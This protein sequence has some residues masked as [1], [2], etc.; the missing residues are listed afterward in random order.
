MYRLLD[1]SGQP[2]KIADARQEKPQQ[3][4]LKRENRPGEPVT[5]VA[6]TTATQICWR[7]V[8]SAGTQT[9]LR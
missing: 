6:E 8:T 1:K 4:A 7:P 9:P 3:A 5:G 2:A